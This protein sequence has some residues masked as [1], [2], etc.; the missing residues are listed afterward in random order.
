MVELIIVLIV[1][2]VV[3]AIAIPRVAVSSE[4]SVDTATASLVRNVRA[5]IEVY[6]AV[7][8][9]YPAT[10]D[11]GW[12][13]GNEIVSPFEPDHPTPLWLASAPNKI[14]PSAKRLTSDSTSTLWYNTVNGMFCARVPSAGGDA[15]TLARFN[16]VNG[17]A[18]TSMDQTE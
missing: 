15:A 2:A 8:G 18:C 9:V 6:Y 7:E 14:Y 1:L 13:L 5:Q 4:G 12:F 17:T 16:R 10:L 3:T 11:A